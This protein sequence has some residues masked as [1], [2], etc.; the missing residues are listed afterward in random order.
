MGVRHQTGP[1]PPPQKKKKKV[2]EE[3]FNLS[4]PRYIDGTADAV[5]LHAR[6]LRHSLQHAGGQPQLVLP[7]GPQLQ[8]NV[9]PPPVRPVPLLGIIARKEKESAKRPAERRKSLSFQ[10][11]LRICDCRHPKMFF[12]RH[13]FCYV[14]TFSLSCWLFVSCCQKKR[15]GWSLTTLQMRLAASF[16][17]SSLSET[18]PTAGKIKELRPSANHPSSIMGS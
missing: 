3:A 18:W 14:L 15:I 13:G 5:A 16:A 2:D 4:D 9:R 10:G 7:P 12:S 8:R 11:I 17:A 1:P 6:S